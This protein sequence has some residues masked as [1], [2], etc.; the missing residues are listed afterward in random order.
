M[1][2]Q[3]SEEEVIL[4]YFGNDIGTFADIGCNDCVTFSN[5]RALALKGWKGIFVDP[6]SKAI[7]NCHKLYDGYKGFYMYPFALGSHNGM[8]TLHESGPLVSA[9]D[10]GLVSTFHSSE[11]DRFKDKVQYTPVPVK[12]FKWKTFLNR[13][14]IKSFDMISMDCEGSEMEI[15]PDM[16]LSKTRLIVLEWNGND[17][18]KKQYNKYLGEFRL[19]YTSGENLIY[20]R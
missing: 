18:L 1:F 14:A 8:G 17:S 13:L 12:V 3:N 15:L 5:T 7:S 6:S 19:I 10:H 9:N 2:S 16:D 11:M 4:K 20:A